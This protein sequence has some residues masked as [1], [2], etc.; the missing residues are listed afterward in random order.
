M[1]NKIFSGSLFALDLSALLK[2]CLLIRDLFWIQSIDGVSWTLEIEMKFYIISVLTYKYSRNYIHSIL[3]L[4]FFITFLT[5]LI[6]SVGFGSY[7]SVRYVFLLDGAFL[8]FMFIGSVFNLVYLKKITIRYGIFSCA[9]M[10]ACFYI[11]SMNGLL[12][13]DGR[14]MFLNYIGAFSIFTISY[15][16]RDIFPN[17]RILSALADLSYPMYAVHGVFGYTM[18]EIGVL[19]SLNSYYILLVTILLVLVLA[20]VLHISVE[21]QSIALFRKLYLGRV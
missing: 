12:S 13:A 21:K 6:K 15:L 18:L 16:Y 20:Y 4:C 3:G 1:C 2:Q 19:Y 9:F 11:T 14:V 17:N 5:I 8:I 10:L 7:D